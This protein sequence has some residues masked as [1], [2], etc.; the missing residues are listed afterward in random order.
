M[1]KVVHLH[2]DM[3]NFATNA[4]WEAITKRKNANN[5][6]NKAIV[7]METGASSSIETNQ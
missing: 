6:T 2:M 5:S 4:T 1:Q 7:S 3:K